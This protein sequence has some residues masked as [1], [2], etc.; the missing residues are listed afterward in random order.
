MERNK[1]EREP[2]VINMQ[3]GTY[4]HHVDIFVQHNHF[5]NNEHKYKEKPVFDLSDHNMMREVLTPIVRLIQNS[6]QWFP[7]Y[8][9]LVD[10]K[11]I[12]KGDYEYFASKMKLIFGDELPK[13]ID[14]KDL[15]RLEVLSFALPFNQW[16][17]DNAP[18]QGQTYRQYSKIGD[19]SRIVFG[20][21]YE[22]I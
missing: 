1:E 9:I 20:I 3:G 14:V 12:D 11:Y 6:R 10:G 22:K 2:N 16:T 15:S 4:N 13:P 17:P 19:Y 21:D 7:L 5:G 18:V 8:R